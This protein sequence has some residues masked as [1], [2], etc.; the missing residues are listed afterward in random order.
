MQ[1]KIEFRPVTPTSQDD[2]TVLV[3]GEAIGTFFWA[4]DVGASGPIKTAIVRS[5]HGGTLLCATDRQAVGWLMK[6]EAIA[7][8]E[9]ANEPN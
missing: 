6:Q 9:Y 4:K 3:N 8:S 5:R 1:P 7:E 2:F